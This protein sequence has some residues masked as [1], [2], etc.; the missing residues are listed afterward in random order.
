LMVGV[1]S[2]RFRVGGLLDVEQFA[3]GDD[4]AARGAAAALTE[5][6]GEQVA[7]GAATLAGEP[8]PAAGAFVDAA[9]RV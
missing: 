6:S 5:A 1:G 3:D 8:V 4:L 7:L 2:D 9:G